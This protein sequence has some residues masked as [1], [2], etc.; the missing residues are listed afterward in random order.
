MIVL[1]NTDGHTVIVLDEVDVLRLRQA[2]SA[3]PDGRFLV[4]LA[5]DLP[6]VAAAFREAEAQ[7]GLTTEKILAILATSV[8]KQ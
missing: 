5:P 1:R 6:W 3:T 2:P 8:A 7:G 4:A